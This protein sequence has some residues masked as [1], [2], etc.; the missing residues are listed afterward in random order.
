MLRRGTAGRWGKRRGGG[1]AL[2]YEEAA[3]CRAALDR[4]RNQLREQEDRWVEHTIEL[5]QPAEQARD[6][7]DDHNLLASYQIGEPGHD[8]VRD[9]LRMHACKVPIT[10]WHVRQSVAAGACAWHCAGRRRRQTGS[11]GQHRSESDA[12][13]ANARSALHQTDHSRVGDKVVV[14]VL[15]PELHRGLR[16]DVALH[17]VQNVRQACAAHSSQR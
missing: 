9:Q 14:K 1:E 13:R 2:A 5:Q 3:G 12:H 15:E 7:T 17:G 10:R 8:W 4:V 11:T 6:G 16:D